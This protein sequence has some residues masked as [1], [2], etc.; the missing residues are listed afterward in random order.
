MIE[1]I[2]NTN[3]ISKLILSLVVLLPIFY[4]P[5]SLSSLIFAKTAL[6]YFFVFVVALCAVFAFLKSKEKFLDFSYFK[7]GALAVVLSYTVS[8]LLSE[9]FRV[10]FWGRDLAIDSWATVFSL[11]LLF[12]LITRHFQKSYALNVIFS[13][14]FVSGLLSIFQLLNILVPSFPTLGIF[15]D[16]SSS[17]LGKVNDLSLFLVV[18]VILITLA[19][20]QLKMTSKFKAILYVIGILNLSLILLINFNLSL[21]III[22]FGVIYSI[23]KFVVYKNINQKL[24]GEDLKVFGASLFLLTISVIWLF[25]GS[26]ISSELSKKLNFNYVEVR[27]SL[28]NTIE[29]SKKSLEQNLFFGSGPAT[30]E[31]MWPQLRSDEVLKT[32]FWNVDFRFGYG[33]ISSFGVTLGSVGVIVW[34]IFLIMVL[35][36]VIKSLLFKTKDLSSKFILD[37]FAIST[38]V[39][40]IISVMYI[41]TISL[42]AL[43]FIFTGILF[44]LLKDIKV[45]EVLK[46]QFN[47]SAGKILAIVFIVVLGIFYYVLLG[48]FVA[49]SYFQKAQFAVVENNTDQALIYLEKSIEKDDLDI[50]HRS[51][52][53]IYTNFLYQEINSEKELNKEEL[54]SIIQKIIQNYDLAIKYDQNNYSNYLNMADFFAEL[55]ALE[56]SPEEAYT[57]STNLY[58]K[59]GQLKPNNPYIELQKSKLSFFNQEYSKAKEGIAKTISLR[60]QYYEAY[61][62]LS[63]MELEMGNGQIAVDTLTEYLKIMPDDHNAMFQLGL[64]YAGVNDYQNA[65]IIFQNLQSI[66]PED[67]NLRGVLENIKNGNL[68]DTI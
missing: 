19:L 11:F 62:A 15:Y 64:L 66:Y 29:I 8:A 20:E 21:Y 26:G 59:A 56:V 34:I 5:A 46:I 28:S 48:K 45:I 38:V 17:I 24:K 67:Q 57:M 12:C 30:F 16:A 44:A 43:A 13:F 14:I 63:Q 41:P 25:F 4:L 40:W 39:L 50:Y 22:G 68:S 49:H 23:Y 53:V 3:L 33:L 27:P 35:S 1:K 54:E 10:S 7:F 42:F 2:F 52:S 36:Y 18:G 65:A 32:D 55:L 51:L 9:S 61:L 60:P 47:Q 37:A 31:R 58:N 6:L